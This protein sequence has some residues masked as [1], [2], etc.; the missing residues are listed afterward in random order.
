MTIALRID[1]PAPGRSGEQPL[2]CA[3]TLDGSTYRRLRD[4]VIN[5]ALEEPPIVIVDVNA[6]HA[7]D[8]SAWSVF[9]SAHWHVCTWP[10][11][12]IVLV[13]SDPTTCDTLRRTGIT[14]HVPVYRT[15]AD[16][17]TACGTGQNRRRKRAR[18]E[19]P[20]GLGGAARARRLVEYWLTDWSHT[21]M[22]PV[23]AII[24]SELAENALLHT[25]SAPWLI[26]EC[27]GDQITV[28]V[29]DASPV[30][31][32]R[33]E[34]PRSGASPVSGLAVVSALSR[35][36]GCLPTVSG[37]TVWAVLGPENAL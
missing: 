17:R 34:H 27:D 26:I 20:A 14:R 6:L 4:I 2:T 15:V 35:S 33:R 16:A 32:Q 37:K 9:T 11:V 7:P 25:D 23:A 30:P 22:I 29:E 12:P 8:A 24:A 28:A 13:C 1:G 5:A 36:W 18:A 21:A 10:D 31:A 19:L 3:G